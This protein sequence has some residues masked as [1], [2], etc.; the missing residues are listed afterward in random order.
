M[1]SYFDKDGNPI[2]V[3]ARDGGY[4]AWKSSWG[5]AFADKEKKRRS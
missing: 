3:N 5:K 4:S 2:N 1:R